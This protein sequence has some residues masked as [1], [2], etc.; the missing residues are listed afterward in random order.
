VGYYAMH[1]TKADLA[2]N[3]DTGVNHIIAQAQGVQLW[4]LQGGLLQ[5]HRIG[6]DGKDYYYNLDGC[7]ATTVSSS[8]LQG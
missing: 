7:G 1:V 5:A 6:K 4:R 3:P 8:S 2:A